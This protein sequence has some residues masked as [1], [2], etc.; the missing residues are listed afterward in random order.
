MHTS[1]VR[2]AV[3]P[4]LLAL[5]VAVLLALVPTG[6]QAA[7][8]PPTLGAPAGNMA[9]GLDGCVSDRGPWNC[10]AECE[11]GGGWHINTGNGFYGGL[12]FG[13]AT[14][15][16]YGGLAYA[17]RADLAT[18]AEQIAVARRVL[19]DQGWDAWPDCSR[20]YGLA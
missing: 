4:V 7:S 8:P 12:Q 19:A 18:R 13:Q 14:W 10:L 11:S 17:P 5:P 3:L 15:E 9:S 6:A 20:K 1:R 16:S 2:P